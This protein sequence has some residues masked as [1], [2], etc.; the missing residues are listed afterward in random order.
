M[1]FTIYHNEDISKLKVLLNG[2]SK[3]QDNYIGG[4]GSRGYGKIVFE[5]INF[6]ARSADDYLSGN[7]AKTPIKLNGK[8]TFTPAEILQN[9]G[10]LE[11]ELKT[12]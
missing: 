9:F 3:L 7:T 1:V 10:L 6:I 2:L 4:S 12:K 11:T 8:E 5:N